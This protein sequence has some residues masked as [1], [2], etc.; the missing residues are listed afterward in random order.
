MNGET[1]DDM[2]SCRNSFAS[3]INITIEKKAIPQGVNIFNVFHQNPRSL[4]SRIC[5]IMSAHN[6]VRLR[7]EN[8]SL[9]KGFHHQLFDQRII[10]VAG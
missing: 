8:P 3:G 2:F 10:A 1:S 5:H 9:W 4:I 7:H 6:S